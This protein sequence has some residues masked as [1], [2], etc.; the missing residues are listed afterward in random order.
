M[1]EALERRCFFAVT[2]T[3]D[4]AVWHQTM[5]GFGSSLRVFDDPHVF[6]N[7]NPATGRA[8]TVLTPAQ[9]GEVMDRLYRDL[10][11]TPR[12]AGQRGDGRRVRHR[13][14]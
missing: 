10:R 4:G 7:F 3:V 6:E 2:V 8:A 1:F 11:L 9:Q 5:D 14:G 13:A 12:Q